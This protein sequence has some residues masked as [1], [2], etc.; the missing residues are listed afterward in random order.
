[1]KNMKKL[2]IFASIIT[3]LSV[4]S[5]SLFI[6]NALENIS[7]TSDSK[8]PLKI[9]DEQTDE[10]E[11]PS[12]EIGSLSGSSGQET[13][14]SLRI[15]SN[16]IY[17]CVGDK[18]D[19]SKAYD[20][21]L[22]IDRIGAC[23]IY[24]YDINMNFINCTTLSLTQTS[25]VYVSQNSEYVRLVYSKSKNEPTIDW[26]KKVG[27]RTIVYSKKN[28]AFIDVD[29][30]KKMLEI[31]NIQSSSCTNT[32]RTWYAGKKFAF[33]GDS[34]THLDSFSCLKKELAP[35]EVADCGISGTT[36]SGSSANAMWQDTRINSLPLDADVI[37]VMGGTN[38]NFQNKPI[39]E[40]SLNN[41]DTNTFVGAYNVLLSKIYY[42]YF[43]GTTGKYSQTIDYS[44]ITRINADRYSGFPYIMIATPFYSIQAQENESKYADAIKEIAM[45]WH[46]PCVDHYYLD[47]IN[48]QNAYRYQDDDIHPNARGRIKMYGTLQGT[49][50]SIEPPESHE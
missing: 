2:R 27:E 12:F 48:D 46:I 6:S 34:I 31:E 16:Y 43:R 18:I 25:A 38:D 13:D 37:H 49:L 40:I 11:S 19:L 5:G 50:M 35:S 30:L 3:I 20:K 39:G 8:I 21:K 29:E 24:H 9:S 4:A 32:K 42:K 14:N 47:G 45:M 28:I 36:I 7:I 10:T 15:R 41:C 23:F 17:L 1:M 33:F 22:G 44:G 26:T